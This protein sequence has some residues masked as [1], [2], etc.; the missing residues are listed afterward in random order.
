MAVAIALSNYLVTIQINNW[1]TWA[2]FSYPLVFL[3]T[4]LS[5]RTLGLKT[6]SKVLLWGF[7]CGLVLSFISAPPRIAI[8][9]GTAFIIAGM[10]N[11]FIF[12]KL[13]ESKQWWYAPAVSSTVASTIDSFLFFG[14]SFIGTSLPWHTLSMGDLAVKLV[15][16]LA[17]L[18]PYKLIVG[19]LIP[20]K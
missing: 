7:I 3:V 4:D 18:P 16:V 6:A 2:S 5:N 12:N 20:N 11:L 10:L 13:R 17:F 19:Y 9:S 14:L 1:L 8:A 15:M